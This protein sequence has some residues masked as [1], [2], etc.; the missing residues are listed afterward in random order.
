MALARHLRALEDAVDGPL[1]LAELSGRLHHSGFGLTVIVMCLPF[2]QPVPMGGLSTVLGPLVALLGVRLCRGEKELRLPAW[3]GRR[4]VE[5]KTLQILLGAARRFFA[6]AETFCRPRLQVLLAHE[7]VTGAGIALAGALLALPFPIP[8]S[9]MICAGP[10]TMLALSTL[11][12]DGLLAV[13]GWLGLILSLAF[14]IGLAVL[15]G[16]ALRL[17]WSRYA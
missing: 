5:E 16:D 8:L 6:V 17:A 7:R 14:H 9:N 10:A 13:L 2:L 15:G 11:E 4:R 1:T 12:D 3:I